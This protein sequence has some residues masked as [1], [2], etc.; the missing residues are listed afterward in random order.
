MYTQLTDRKVWYDGTSSYPPTAVTGR[1][2]VQY[3]DGLTADIQALNTLLPP[4]KRIAVKTG[5]VTPTPE[6]LV[7]TSDADVVDFIAIKF[8][9]HIVGMS[10]SEISVRERRLVQELELF[11]THQMMSLLATAIYVVESLERTHSVW[12]VGRGSST[13]SFVLFLIGLH[14]IDPIAFDIPITDFF[15]PTAF[16]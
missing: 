3:V 4:Y 13:S 1:K 16:G 8:A 15:K 12:G 14:D 9:D 6:W 2:L 5:A 10:E 7:Q 11:K